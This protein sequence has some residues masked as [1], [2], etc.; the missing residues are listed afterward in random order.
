MNADAP[1]GA[2]QPLLGRADA[3][4]II[5]GIVI[6]AGIF[7]TPSMVAGVTGD[8]GWM[9]VAWVLGAVVSL[10][11]ALCYAELATTYPHA[12]GDYHFLTR[13][14][15]RHAS[16]LY[17]WA[18]ATV[19]NTG[20]IALL[21][22]VFGDY[23]QKVL[24]LG[25]AG[26]ALWG[27]GIVLALTAVN[28]AGLRASAGTQ[29]LLTLV[30]VAGLIAIGVAGF[31]A[32][33]AAAA[34]PAFTAAPPLGMFGLAMVFVLL[35]YGGWNEAAYISAE[36]KGG[37]RE[38]VTVLVWSLA[39]IAT[40][41]LVVNLALLHGLGLKGL[42]DSKAAGADVME[43]VFGTAGAQAL[44]LFVAVAALT[45]INATMIVGARTNYAMGR[46]WPALRFMGGWHATRGTPVAAFV[47]QGV[48]A[49]ALVAFGAMQHDGFE[50]MV[51]FTAPVFWGFLFLVGLALF[52]LRGKDAGAERPFR[53]PLYPLTPLVF[54]AACAWLCY[55]SVTY[56]MSRNAV[57]VSLL[58]MAVGVVA[59]FVTRARR[60]PPRVTMADD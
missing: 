49:L 18:R 41:Y 42:A 26:G 22:F 55:S 45:S 39:I 53:V 43:R 5:V 46:D 60:P 54:C 32:P 10:A 8:V 28:I 40:V 2:P 19:I 21:A 14:W 25:T 24:P 16:F 1:Q 29:K 27:A 48:I 38:I 20:A 58:V 6:G 3:I 15:G 7:K 37:R 52:I 57:H 47:V 30:E 9:L 4:A 31:M 59:L 50:A 33:A 23:M 35:T 56:A 34:A 17:A 51:E 11:G 44:S 36:L 13:A 12:G